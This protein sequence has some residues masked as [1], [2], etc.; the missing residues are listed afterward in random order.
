MLQRIVRQLMGKPFTLLCILLISTTVLAS[1]PE[2]FLK[3]APMPFYP[4][5]ALQARIQGEVIV[6]VQISKAGD[7]S[8][9]ALSGHALLRSATMD[10]VKE[11]KF[12][13]P[14]PCACEISRE[15]TFVYKIAPDSPDSPTTSVRW[16]G[17]SRV[18]I[19][20]ESLR[21]ETETANRG[22]SH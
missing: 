19:D 20:G 3:S 21:I 9:E 4:R 8:V 1:D 12:G 5:L 16:F 14:Y 2:P 11:W 18:E 13:W 7:T 22:H 17:T 6:R 15:V 10:Y